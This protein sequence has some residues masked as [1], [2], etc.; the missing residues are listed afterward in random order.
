M[1]DGGPQ[2]P[3]PQRFRPFEAL[4]RP[5]VHGHA[6]PALDQRRDGVV[7]RALGQPE[8]HRVMPVDRVRAHESGV[9]QERG[10]QVERGRVDVVRGAVVRVEPQPG[11]DLHWRLLGVGLGRGG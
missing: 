9:E 5:V 3:S 11:A 10:V 8:R 6:V 7:R 2:S 1:S 4:Q